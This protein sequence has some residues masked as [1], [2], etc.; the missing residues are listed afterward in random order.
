MI[1]ILTRNLYGLEKQKTHPLKFPP[2]PSIYMKE[3]LRNN[4]AENRR[5]NG[6]RLKGHREASGRLTGG[7]R[8]S[9]AK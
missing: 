3:L 6:R 2:Y 8:N 7:R 1:P 9:F 5:G 4:Y